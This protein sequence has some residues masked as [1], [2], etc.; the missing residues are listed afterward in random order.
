M[1]SRLPILNM[2]RSSVCRWKGHSA[3]NVYGDE[4]TGCEWYTIFSSISLRLVLLLFEV[5]QKWRFHSIWSIFTPTNSPTAHP[6][7]MNKWRS[8]SP[9]KFN[10]YTKRD[11]EKPLTFRLKEDRMTCERRE[12]TWTFRTYGI[13]HNAQLHCA[14]EHTFKTASHNREIDVHKQCDA[15]HTPCTICVYTCSIGCAI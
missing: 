14:D 7:R 11:D 13:Y 10:V 3:V 4:P 9:A 2:K 15:M 5:T 12:S 6:T 1:F 8:F